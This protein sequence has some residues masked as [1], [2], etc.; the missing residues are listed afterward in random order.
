MTL[1]NEILSFNKAFVQNEEYE[2]FERNKLPNKRV[3]ILSCMDT[4]LVELLPKSMNIAN[5]D[6]KVVKT[7]GALVSE[8][9]GNVMQSIIVGVYELNVDEVCVIGHYDC[10]MGNV[11]ADQTIEKMKK[12]GVTQEKL[13]TLQNAGVNLDQFLNGF[14]DVEDSVKTSV[15]TIRNHPLIPDNI[16]VHGL[17]IDP[18]TGRLD[19]VEE[20]YT[21]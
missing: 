12:R 17:I 11:K 20:G 13:D 21:K 4:R 19:L 5:G 18:N 1:L 8:P 3:L 9:F 10:G 16:P 6:A 14:A 7:A 15:S 2:D